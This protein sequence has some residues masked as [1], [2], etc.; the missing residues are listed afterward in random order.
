VLCLAACPQEVAGYSNVSLM[1]AIAQINYLVCCARQLAM[2]GL[3]CN[4]HV[5]MQQHVVCAR[6]PQPLSIYILCVRAMLCCPTTNHE[7]L[8]ILLS[9]SPS[10]QHPDHSPLEPWLQALLRLST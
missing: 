3:S 1:R 2:C 8:L 7:A 4:W 10:L 9:M 6:L 5:A